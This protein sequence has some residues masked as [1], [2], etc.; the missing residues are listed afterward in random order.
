MSATSHTLGNKK[1]KHYIDLDK[2]GRKLTKYKG[3][4]GR[5]ARAISI[6]FEDRIAQ[7]SPL[8]N[9][10]IYSNEEFPWV[11]NLEKEWRTIRGELEKVLERRAELPSFHEITPEVQTI[12]QDQNWKTFF[13]A[14]YGMECHD[15]CL[16]CPETTRLLGQV[17][18][19]KTAFFSILSPHKHIPPHRGPYNG[20]LR[21]H[22][23]LIVPEPKENCRIQIGD[24]FRSWSE[25]ECIIFDDTFAH[26]VW[27][28]TEGLRAVLFLDVERPLRFPMDLVNRALLG[29]AQF[30]T[31]LRRSAK[32][33]REWSKRF[34]KN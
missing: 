1:K 8:G 11:T 19:L 17:P 31:Y 13:L 21:C 33:H 28:D 23:A 4:R 24:E 26:Q 20:V 2:Q 7:F 14:G 29:A 10:P 5:M 30:T 25:G 22:L 32:N 18:G 9:P 3:L 16:A 6:W 34:Y 15:N 27:N 12:T